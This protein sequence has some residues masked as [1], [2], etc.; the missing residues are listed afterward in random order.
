MYC[1]NCGKKLDNNE[2]Q[3]FCPYCGYQIAGKEKEVSETIEK[4]DIKKAVQETIKES[5]AEAVKEKGKINY[6]PI[7][8]I[9]MLG[10]ALATVLLFLKWINV[11]VGVLRNF[12]LS[13]IP[14]V[15][16]LFG[17]GYTNKISILSLIALSGELGL[18]GSD[19]F[20]MF[21][22][23][24]SVLLAVISLI[25]F[26]S[27]GRTFYFSAISF[28]VMMCVT[29]LG[30]LFFIKY[31]NALVNA[32]ISRLTG[33]NIGSALLGDI[34]TANVFLFIEFGI[35]VAG[36][37]VGIH[38]YRVNRERIL[39]EKKASRT[40]SFVT[41]SSII[42]AVFGSL[43]ILFGIFG[44]FS[45]LLSDDSG[46]LYSL[47][48][49]LLSIIG[50]VIHIIISIYGVKGKNLYTLFNRARQIASL[51]I[52]IVLFYVIYDPIHEE[53]MGRHLYYTDSLQGYISAFFLVGGIVYLPM[54][55][56][57]ILLFL[58]IRKNNKSAN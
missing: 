33:V 46:K 2:N 48:M 9:M 38:T 22:Y 18:N 37:I 16:W 54:V 42:L 7:E 12:N 6:Q 30:G 5:M 24:I 45:N 47:L 10:I 13:D 39:N 57:S 36:I 21:A 51:E 17:L 49:V 32:L 34:F 40:N 11:D 56:Y 4:E 23:I 50:G 20:M 8:L 19:K 15:G 3:K 35:G 25:S 29:S 26:W 28:S 53:S 1:I 44:F 43:F 41:I 27:R 55:I 31:S 52:C 58:I 14:V